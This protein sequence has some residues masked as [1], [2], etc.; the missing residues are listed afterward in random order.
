MSFDLLARSQV[1]AC[2]DEDFLC[3][4]DNTQPATWK[5]MNKAWRRLYTNPSETSPDR[6]F[7]V[8]NMSALV[9]EK[10][11]VTLVYFNLRW[12]AMGSPMKD[13]VV[14]HTWKRGNDDKWMLASMQSIHGSNVKQGF[15]F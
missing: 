1:A 12:R 5:Q 7:E 13:W 8:E 9:D 3:K 10:K 6:Y 11:G 4:V 14:E 2:I 15:G